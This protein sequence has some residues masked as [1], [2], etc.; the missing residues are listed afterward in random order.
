MFTAL[1]FTVKLPNKMKLG[2]LSLSPTTSSVYPT[3]ST[4]FPTTGSVSPTASS[5]SSVFP[6]YNK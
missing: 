3:T 5:V 4:V 6:T 2:A 1:M